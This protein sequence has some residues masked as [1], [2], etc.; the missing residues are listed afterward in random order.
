MRRRVQRV[1]VA[2]LLLLL[3]LASSWSAI[4]SAMTDRWLSQDEPAQTLHAVVSSVSTGVPVD[5]MAVAPNGKFAYVVNANSG[6]L[7]IVNLATH[8]R[9]SVRV[10]WNLTDVAVSPNGKL[11]YITSYGAEGHYDRTVYALDTKT[12]RIIDSIDV[13]GSSDLVAFSPNGEVA[14]VVMTT[15]LVIINVTTSRVA[16][17]I[18]TGTF[19]S[20]I[21]AVGPSGDLVYLATDPSYGSANMPSKFEVINVSKRR[22]V[23][24]ISQ[25]FTGEPCSMTVDPDGARVYESF[26][27]L[28][29]GMGPEST[30]IRVLNGRSGAVESRIP[31]AARGLAA[32]AEGDT[33][34]A[35]DYATSTL[36]IINTI[37]DKPV[38]AIQVNT[39]SSDIL[40]DQLVIGTR[41]TTLYAPAFDP[42]SLASKL[43]II[44]L[45]ADALISKRCA[46]VAAMPLGWRRY[47]ESNTA[48]DEWTSGLPAE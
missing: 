15:R 48:V 1:G 34:V 47:S 9:T 14:Y 7:V 30:A 23:A 36:H 46:S 41:E 2:M 17:R 6:S 37:N 26:D 32:S 16:A 44:R 12:G 29:T 5:A 21:E 42:L 38:A 3:P 43:F 31:V 13:G 8:A 10:G 11:A 40:F 22:M 27:A 19:L 45:P 24:S 39:G 35:A 4:A 18:P 20:G 28:P 25:G 33:L